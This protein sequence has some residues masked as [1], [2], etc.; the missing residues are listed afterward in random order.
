M[1]RDAQEKGR[2]SFELESEGHQGN[3]NGY[4]RYRKAADDGGQPSNFTQLDPHDGTPLLNPGPCC[5]PR[6][7][8]KLRAPSMRTITYKART[9]D[10]GKYLLWKSPLG[11]SH[12][13]NGI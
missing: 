4:A 1:G 7:K 8:T 12:F 3:G 11:S 5:P 10:C 13:L 9:A 6:T 2:T